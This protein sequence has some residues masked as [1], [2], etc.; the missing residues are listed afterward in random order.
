MQN[1]L[2]K[3][4]IRYE[5]QCRFKIGIM[6]FYLPDAKIALFVD[7]TIW[8]ADPRV[9]EEH[10]QLFFSK[11]ISRTEAWKKVTAK[12]VWLKDAQHNAYLESRGFIVIRFW[13]KEIIE[14]IDKCIELIR[15][16]SSGR[17]SSEVA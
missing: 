17:N 8:H 7:G 13:E 2:D 11:K 15:S 4:K 12:E 14:N 5:Q 10:E 3:N 6:D 9:Y 1:A 16:K